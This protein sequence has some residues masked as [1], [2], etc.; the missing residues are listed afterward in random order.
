MRRVDPNE[1]ELLVDFGGREVPYDFG[2]LDA[3]ALAYAATV[4]KAQGSE[5]PPVVI[6][7]T[8]QHFPMLKVGDTFDPGVAGRPCQLVYAAGDSARAGRG[9]PGVPRPAAVA[10]P[11]DAPARAQSFGRR[12]VRP[13]PCRRPVRVHPNGTGA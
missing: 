4:H 9:L 10:R 11:A 7:L 1:G 12:G 8:T 6:P 5:Y 13:L 3:L 2:E